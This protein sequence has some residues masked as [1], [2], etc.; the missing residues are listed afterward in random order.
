MSKTLYMMKGLPASGKSTRARELLGEFGYGNAKIVNKDQLR[1]ML[2]D[3]HWSGSNEK[4]VLRVRDFV[5]D[6]ALRGGLHVIVD[7]TNLA[8]KH[9]EHLRVMA[10][11]CGAGFE[12]VDFTGVGVDEC[13]ERDRRRVNYVGERVIREMHARFLAVPAAP[14]VF[15]P[16]LP[17]VIIV[18]VDGTVAKMNGRGPFEWS[19]VG[20]DD[21]RVPIANVLDRLD[22]RIGDLVFVSGRDE[23]CRPQTEQWL[24]DKFGYEVLPRL[25]MRPTGDTRKDVVVKR[26][27]YEREI[28]GKYNVVAVFDDRPQVIRLWRELGFGDRLFDVG[29]GREF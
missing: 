17:Y 3:G 4:F 6:A 12:V 13:V 10:K 8:P 24:C 25:W 2:D 19:R 16:A 1:A 20:E 27:I 21:I 9:E 5:I 23:V 14:P 26:E 7:D 28:K 22:G 15:D 11:A 18:D 29:D